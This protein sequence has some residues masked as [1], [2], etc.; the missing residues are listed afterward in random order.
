MAAAMTLILLASIQAAA[1]ALSAAGSVTCPPPGFDSVP[2]FDVM[3]FAAA[4]WY[5][6]RQVDARLCNQPVLSCQ[7]RYHAP[8]AHLVGGIM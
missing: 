8:S 1:T 2:D 3:A 5:I 7:Y 4:P 6:R